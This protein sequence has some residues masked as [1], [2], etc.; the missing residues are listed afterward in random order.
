MTSN[1]LLNFHERA[2]EKARKYSRD[3]FLEA[4]HKKLI[5]I[6]DADKV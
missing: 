2:A 3:I 5:S 6:F 4:Y 1:E